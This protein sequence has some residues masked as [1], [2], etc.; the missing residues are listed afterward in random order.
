MKEK[1]YWTIQ[2]FS[3]RFDYFTYFDTNPYLADQLFFR[4]EVRVWFD[5][6]Y[7]KDGFPYRAILCHVRKRDVPR[8]LEALEDLKNSMLICGH[9]DYEEEVSRFMA[10]AEKLKEANYR[11][12][13]TA[14]K[15]K[16]TQP[17]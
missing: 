7:E 2:K 1:L 3:L 5:C 10:G 16:Q 6:E 13:G 4:H 12:N 8:F 15:A 17:A 11:E 9:T 14:E